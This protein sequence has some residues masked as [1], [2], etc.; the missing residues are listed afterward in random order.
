MI[1]VKTNKSSID[2]VVDHL[3]DNLMSHLCE[4]LGSSNLF[5]AS[6]KIETHTLYRDVVGKKRDYVGKIPKLGGGGSDP[7]PLLDV[8]LIYLKL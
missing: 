3:H 7:N 8:Y 4:V 2:F 6:T 5:C 1:E